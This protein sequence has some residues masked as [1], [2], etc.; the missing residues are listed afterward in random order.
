MSLKLELGDHP[1][2]LLRVKNR[3]IPHG[4]ERCKMPKEHSAFATRMAAE[5]FMMMVNHGYP[6]VDAL[7]AVYMTGID[8]ALNGKKDQARPAPAQLKEEGDA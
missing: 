5:T 4:F 8:H 2:S 1:G 3:R 7:T 6:F